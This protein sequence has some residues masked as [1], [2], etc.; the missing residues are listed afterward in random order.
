[1]N[2][3]SKQP[4]APTIPG[5]GGAPIA[6]TMPMGGSDFQENIALDAAED[7]PF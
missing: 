2:I 5:I 1:M 4:K 7:M 6:P 3:E